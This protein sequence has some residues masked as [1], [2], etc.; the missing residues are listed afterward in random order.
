MEQENKKIEKP[1]NG[2]RELDNLLKAVF[3]GLGRLEKEEN[4]P[5]NVLLKG[6][7]LIENFLEELLL[8][9]KK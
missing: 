5:S 1:D 9:G 4:D 8:L 2:G 6:H 7:L 3:G